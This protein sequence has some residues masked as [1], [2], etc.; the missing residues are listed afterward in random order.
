[1]S[2]ID[3]LPYDEKDMFAAG[4]RKARA[5]LRVASGDKTNPAS[6][7][8]NAIERSDQRR[9]PPITLPRLKFMNEV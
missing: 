4:F 2:D 9:N 3:D 6:A 5:F 7:V 8:E 1:M